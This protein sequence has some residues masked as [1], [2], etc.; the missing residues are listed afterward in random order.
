MILVTLEKYG[1]YPQEIN[2]YNWQS[3]H[4]LVVAISWI[5]WSSN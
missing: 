4:E 5:N 1:M 3:I 2:L